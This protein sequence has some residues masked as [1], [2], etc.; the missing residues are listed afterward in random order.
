MS[1]TRTDAIVYLYTLG[2]VVS[3]GL[4][5]VQVEISGNVPLLVISS[6]VAAGWLAYFRR[7]I[8]PLLEAELT[9]DE[10]EA[11]NERGSSPAHD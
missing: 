7:R 3:G 9:E 2:A 1:L 6:I 11:T 8:L 4:L 5:V 10:D